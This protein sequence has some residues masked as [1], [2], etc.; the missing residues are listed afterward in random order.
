MPAT[1][2]NIIHNFFFFDIF[3]KLNH[4]ITHNKMTLLHCENK[5]TKRLESRANGVMILCFLFDNISLP[6]QFARLFPCCREI[7]DTC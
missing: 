1:I 3:Q 6:V 5:G 4:I 7:D 2:D